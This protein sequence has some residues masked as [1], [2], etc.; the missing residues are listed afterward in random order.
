LLFK[1]LFAGNKSNT[2]DLV[3]QLLA[4]KD[5]VTSAN[6]RVVV[7]YERLLEEKQRTF[8]VLTE[9]DSVLNSHYLESEL[10]YK[11]I[12]AS[13]SKIP[14]RI[15]ALSGHSDSIIAAFHNF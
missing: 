14:E 4:Q 10:T 9:R 3:K 12:N 15:N 2:D 11:N 13:L 5:S 6:N 7:M 1:T 8:E